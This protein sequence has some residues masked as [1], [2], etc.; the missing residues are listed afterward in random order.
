MLGPNGFKTGKE[1]FCFPAVETFGPGSGGFLELNARV[2][3]VSD[4]QKQ[5]AEVEM[6]ESGVW[7]GARQ[8]AEPRERGRGIA[9]VEAP[10][11]GRHLRVQSVRRELERAVERGPR[12]EWLADP[13]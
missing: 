3:N 6:D 4:P 1:R 12:G 2:L 9:L 8:R 7:V 13:L 11:G 5:H 10:D